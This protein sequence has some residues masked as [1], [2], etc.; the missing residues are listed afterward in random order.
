[1][2]RSIQRPG[3]RGTHANRSLTNPDCDRFVSRGEQGE[4]TDSDMCGIAGFSLDGDA[5]IDR[6][7][8]AQALLAGI[9]ER[10]ADAA[11]YAYRSPGTTVSLHKQRTGASA[12]LDTVSLPSATTQALVHV[13]DFTKG[14]PT[15]LANNHPIRHGSIVGIHNGI[16]VN[17]EEIFLRHGLARAE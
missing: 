6:T 9:A 1:V 4:V 14:H 13:R 11:G 10:G 15:I 3:F 16:V 12:L 7:L 2:I 5:T 17:D 8:A